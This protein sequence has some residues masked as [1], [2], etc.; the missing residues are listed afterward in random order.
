MSGEGKQKLKKIE[1]ECKKKVD[2]DIM[3]SS[4]KR[5]DLIYIWI[6]SITVEL[7]LYI[8]LAHS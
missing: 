6:N 7:I 4:V 2:I 1:K 5:R 3:H 8:N